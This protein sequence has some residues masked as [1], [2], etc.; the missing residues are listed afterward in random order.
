MKKVFKEAMEEREKKMKALEGETKNGKRLVEDE[1][2]RIGELTRQFVYE[3]SSMWKKSHGK[4]HLK[5]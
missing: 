5:G 1:L 2:I 3:K 4:T